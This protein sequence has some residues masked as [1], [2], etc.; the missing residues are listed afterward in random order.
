MLSTAG[1]GVKRENEKQEAKSNLNRFITMGM[2][3]KSAGMIQS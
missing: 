2:L 1:Q 3:N